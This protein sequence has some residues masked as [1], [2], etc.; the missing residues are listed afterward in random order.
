M[1]GAAEV[2][3]SIISKLYFSLYVLLLGEMKYDITSISTVQKPIQC[4]SLLCECFIDSCQPN[5]IDCDLM[6][7]IS[8]VASLRQWL[9]AQPFPLKH[10]AHLQKRKGLVRILV[11]VKH[12]SA[13]RLMGAPSLCLH[14]VQIGGPSSLMGYT[15]A[16]YLPSAGET[17]KKHAQSAEIWKGLRKWSAC[18]WLLYVLCFWCK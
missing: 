3:D 4:M 13:A 18:L 17:E 11:S 15:I 2:G 10:R 7:Y 5:L 16:A 8:L 12:G 1:A 6:Q 14:W 9:E